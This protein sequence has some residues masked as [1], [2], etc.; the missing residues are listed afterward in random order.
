MGIGV[1]GGASSGVEEG[2]GA[3]RECEGREQQTGSERKMVV[4]I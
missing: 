3:V 1:V 2:D 4:N